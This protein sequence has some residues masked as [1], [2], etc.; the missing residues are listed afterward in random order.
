MYVPRQNQ[1]G[2]IALHKIT[3]HISSYFW[4]DPEFLKD[5]KCLG[6]KFLTKKCLN[7]IFFQPNCNLELKQ[8]SLTLIFTIRAFRTHK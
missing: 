4:L 1:F 3:F 6:Y 7:S 8:L 5:K 2:L